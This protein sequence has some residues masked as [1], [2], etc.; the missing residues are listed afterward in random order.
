[1][2]LYYL[3]IIIPYYKL[4]FFEETLQSLVSQTDKRFKV[5]IG[6]DASSENPTSLLDKFRDKLDFEYHRFETNLGGI[7]L[8]KQ[9]ERCIALSNNEEWLMVLGD[10]DCIDENLVEEFYKNKNIFENKTNLVRFASKTFRQ[11]TSTYSTTYNH[12]EWEKASDSYFRRFKE[13]TRS[14]LSEYIFTRSVFLNHKFFDYPIGWHSDDWA[15]ME[16]SENKPIFT[17]NKSIIK[18]RV[19]A[20]SLSGMHNNCVLKNQATLQF[21]EN[22]INTKLGSFSKQQALE[23]LMEYEIHIKRIRKVELKE[24]F[25]LLRKYLL[26]F[27]CLSFVKLIRRMLITMTKL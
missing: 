8:T 27:K 3:A 19:S 17:I 20:F 22:I 4:A 15:W 21:Y 13:F 11:E 23:L 7:S 26:N 16:F 2:S 25:L 14:S 6:D 5:Y 1:M 10:D 18:I 9:W 12:P 24:W